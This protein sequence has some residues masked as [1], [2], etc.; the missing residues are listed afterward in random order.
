MR[1]LAVNCGSS[2]FKF[3]VLDVLEGGPL[4]EEQRL[5]EGIVDR[6]GGRAEIR[7][8]SAGGMALRRSLEVTDHA[9][10]AQQV[11]RWLRS[12]GLMGPGGIEA[13]GHRVVHGGGLFLEPVLIDDRVL[14]AIE[15]AAGLA[16]LHN[17][18]ALG[19]IR[20]ARAVDEGLPMVATFDT[21]FHRTLPDRAAQYAIPLEL[22]AKHG[23]R[24]YGFHGLA[25]RYMVERYAYITSRPVQE[26]RLITMQLGNGCSIAAVEGGRSVD[27]SMGFTPLEGLVMGTRCGD[28][29]PSLAGYLAHREGVSVEEVE[30]WLNT[31]S[32]L[33]GLSGRSA[34]MREL[35]QAEAQGD[36]RA[37]LAV[38]AF[39][40]RARKYLGAYLVVLG[41]ADAVI[42]GGGI[43]ENA[44]AVRERICAGMGWCGLE[45]DRGRNAR[46]VGSEGRISRDGSRIDVYVIPV[47]EAAV[48]AR[49][50]VRCLRRGGR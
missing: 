25:H 10:A 38:E 17:A 5:A 19:A 29:D 20:A 15:G 30:G 6:I 40:Y 2:T 26:V 36:S 42:L 35:L 16:P 41:G 39:C 46:T 21:A 43:G 45:L 47:D 18:P 50:T 49:D 9:T 14:A 13:I 1:V 22:A 12:I 4:G 23:I 3:S 31:R 7:F 28:V 24:R 27:T 44:P 34:D 32:G 33:L 8:T 37:A 11:M 48:I